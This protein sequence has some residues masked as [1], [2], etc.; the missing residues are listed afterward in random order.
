MRKKR[1]E[2]TSALNP[3]LDRRSFVKVASIAGTAAVVASRPLLSYATQNAVYGNPDIPD[4]DSRASIVRSVCLMC[5]SACGIQAKVVDGQVVKIDGNPYHPN[6]MDPDERLPF[7]TPPEEADL[8][9][10]HN[11]VKSQAATQT[12]YDPYRLRQP[13]KRIGPRGSGQWEEISWKQALDEIAEVMREY[14]QPD[15]PIDPDFPEFGNMPNMV[16]FSA[17]RIEHGQKEFTDRIFKGGFGTANYRHDHTSI[18]EISHHTGGDLV[19]D[20]K[21]HHWKPDILNSDYL[22]WFGTRPLEAG[23]PMNLLAR[24]IA[25]FLERGGKMATV[26]PVFSNTAARSHQWMPIKPGADAALALAIARWMI[27]NGRYD[28]EFLTNTTKDV[29]GEKSYSDSCFLVDLATGE[30]VRDAGGK[31][32]V[33]NDGMAYN[34]DEAPGSKGEL[35]PGVV[36]VG[37]MQARTVFGLFAD[38]VREKTIEEYAEICGLEASQIMTVAREFAAAGKRGVANA[39]RGAV[40]HTNGTYA[41]MAIN[42]LNILNGNFDWMGGNTTGGSHY[43]EEGG[44]VDGQ[45]KLKTVPDGNSPSGVP[46]SRHGKNYE[47]DAPN[48]FARDGF[49]AKRPWTPFNVRWNF[50]EVLPSIKDAYPYPTEVLITYWNDMLY[51]SPG[52]RASGEA[53]L[54]D[55]SKIKVHVAF[56][57]LIGETSAWADYILPDTTW[58]ERWSTPHVSPAVISTTSGYRQPL[59]G[60]YINQEIDGQ[61]RRFY[62]SPFS[63][64]N[65]A[66]DFWQNASDATGPQLLEDIMIALGGRIGIPGVGAGAF[67]ISTG[68]PGYDWRGGLY[69]GWDWFQNILNNFAIEA[70]TTVDDIVAK[71]GAFAPIVGDPADLDGMYSGGFVKKQYKHIS[72]FYVEALATSRDSMTGETR[73]PLPMQEP[74][75]DSLGREVEHSSGFDFQLVTYKNVYHAQA[76]T[77]CN[78]WLQALKPAG[79]IDLNTDDGRSLGIGDGDMI[80]LVGPDGPVAEGRVRLTHGIRPGVV[81]VPHSYGHWEMGSNPNHTINGVAVTIDPARGKGVAANPLMKLDPHLGD[82]TLQDTIGASASFYDTLVRVERV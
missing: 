22:I 4:T 81:A 18:C 58:L 11:C 20:F 13:L 14:Y 36:T 69:S 60:S 72:H 82:V 56:D 73:D 53:V 47:N 12:L 78:P 23:F 29:N 21:K 7:T 8:V 30:F 70:G 68:A 25:G 15:T 45:V 24:K 75:K 10:G 49:P 38:R 67:D 9:R 35:D 62:V 52:T 71:G 65:V 59:V 31:I 42:A 64:G 3:N 76:R 32:M 17:G 77:I 33:W 55:E 50:Q 66:L 27:D 39:Y 43:H 37:G 80:R 1:L 51:S 16:T 6:C 54:A 79:D 26:D 41:F 46:I 74:I 19:S 48:L 57:I 44:K 34:V 2:R 28:A 63:Q 61:D 40:Q 5:H